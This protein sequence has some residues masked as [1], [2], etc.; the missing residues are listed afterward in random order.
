M[1]AAFLARLGLESGDARPD[2][3]PHG[4]VCPGADDCPPAIPADLAGR[5]GVAA[6]AARGGDP[7]AAPRRLASAGRDD[8]GRMEPSGRSAGAGG[9]EPRN[10]VGE[11]A[12]LTAYAGAEPGTVLWDLITAWEACDEWLRENPD[13]PD[14]DARGTVLE[15]MALEIGV[16]WSEG[17]LLCN[18]GCGARTLPHVK[19]RW[20]R[21]RCIDCRPAEAVTERPAATPAA[22]PD[23]ALPE[24]AEAR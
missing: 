21:G 14:F 16:Y 3:Q 18:G 5:E 7:P 11:A 19:A 12:P 4:G 13:A 22:E 6:A 8:S 10:P 24:L 15:R 1:R 23:L 17:L 9:S 2:S 20:P